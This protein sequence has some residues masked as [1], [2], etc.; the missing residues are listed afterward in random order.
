MGARLFDSHFKIC[1]EDRLANGLK[2]QGTSFLPHLISHS[3]AADQNLTGYAQVLDE[4]QGSVVSRTYSYG[5]SQINEQ[6]TLAGT[7]T[8][9]FYGFD[10][11]GSVRFLTSSTGAVTDT[12]DYDAF[13]NLIAST[14]STP[15]NYRF[16]GEQFDPLLGIYYN[17]ARYYDQRQGR[18]WSMDDF[19]G[20]LDEPLALHRY[21]FAVENPVNNVD[22]SGH[23]AEVDTL[24]ALSVGGTI[25]GITAVNVLKVL[26]VV[27]SALLTGVGLASMT[28]VLLASRANTAELKNK[29]EKLKEEIEEKQKDLKTKILFHYT[30][31]EN[32]ESI[33][34]SGEILGFSGTFGL[35]A[36]ATDI[37][38]FLAESIMRRSQLTTIIFGRNTPENYA[39]TSWFV[40]FEQSPRFSFNKVAPFIYLSPR[41]ATPVVPILISPNLLGE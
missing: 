39:R 4:L 21:T 20:S 25:E 29:R 3:E 28:D 22:P 37:A 18:F 19:E 7:P 15:N 14:G 5:L 38:G 27:T 41:R 31:Q 17:R 8:T 9:S 32:A 12:Y 34:A 11:H 1:H 30:T 33:F 36:Y 23:D 24:G 6:Q 40:A 16:A 10:G 26:G 2:E 35:G 13:G